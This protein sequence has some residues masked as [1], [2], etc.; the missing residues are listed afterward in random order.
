MADHILCIGNGITGVTAARSLRKASPD[1][2]I[3]LISGETRIPYSR[4]ALMYVFMGQLRQRD[5]W[6]YPPEFFEANRIELRT[7]WVEGVETAAH[8]IR[9][10]SGERIPYDALLLATGSV[11]DVPDVPGADLYGVTGFYSLQ[12]L[13]RMEE[14]LPDVE[15]ALVVGGG[16]I[17]V[18]AAE[19]LH[20]RGVAV[21]LLNRGPH[22]YPS[23]LP[24]EEGK[25]VGEE[26]LRHGIDLRLN[27]ELV[28]LEAGEDGGV[29]RAELS[30]GKSLDCQLVVFATGVRPNLSAIQHSTIAM[31]RGVL[32]DRM[33]STN[34]PQVWAA[35]D[36]AE[37]RVVRKGQPA[38]ESMWYTGRLQ[39]VYAARN[40]MGERRLYDP[41]LYYNVAKF[42]T[43][44]WSQYGTI[45]RRNSIAVALFQEGRRIVRVEAPT[46][47]GGIMG[48]MATGVRIRQEAAER[49]LNEGITLDDVPERLHELWFEPELTPYFRQ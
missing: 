7:G 15:R 35:G 1:L 18:E 28:A 41:G 8:R 24:P 2:R 14:R 16:L 40:I 25:L 3:T 19:M 31:N 4:T 30:D 47:R 43:L 12:D 34:A 37:Q 21:T 49:W 33:L 45:T 20:S 46:P 5:T 23:V 9:M 44:D 13:E 27:T 32:V 22:Y 38:I 42:F 11:P 29:G 10:A 6:L 48:I 39:G 26:I 17:G 36:C